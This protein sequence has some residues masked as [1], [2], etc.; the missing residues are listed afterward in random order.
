MSIVGIDPGA[1]GAV[2]IIT[3]EDYSVFDMPCDKM[4]VMPWELKLI[5]STAHAL[6]KIDHVLIEE[7]HAMPK[8]GVS[9]T[10]TFGKGFGI[11]I[12]VVGSLGI[13]FSFVRPQAWQKTFSIGKDTKADAVSIASRLFPDAELYGPKGGKKDG[14]AD[15]LLV[16]EYGRRTLK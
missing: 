1:K 6:E 12:G 13:P 8:Q 10:F 15:A 11:I 7:V 5:F 14:R 2:G 3:R 9:S 16:A 4:G